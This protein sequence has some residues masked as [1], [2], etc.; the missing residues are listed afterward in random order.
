[1]AVELFPQMTP[2]VASS[3]SA[4]PKVSSTVEDIGAVRMGATTSL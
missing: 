3:T 4:R 1:M 2:I